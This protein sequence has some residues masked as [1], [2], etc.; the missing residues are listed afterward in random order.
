MTSLSGSVLATFLIFCRIGTCLMLVPGY[1]SSNV[2][3]QVRLFLAISVTL[4]LTPLL[5]ATV[6]PVVDGATTVAI[7]R[8]DRLRAGGR[9]RHRPDRARVL[10]RAPDHGD[11]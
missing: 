5:E 4:M 1:S 7:I 2:P 10:P 11:A 9:P 8:A 6:R 3:V